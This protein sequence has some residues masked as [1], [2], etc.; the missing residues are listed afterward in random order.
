MPTSSHSTAC[1]ALST[2]RPY[3]CRARQSAPA[4]I[5]FDEID[6]LAAARSEGSSGGGVGARVLSQLLTEMDGLQVIP[7]LLYPWSTQGIILSKG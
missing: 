2:A 7:Q 4:I 1:T 3:Y 5:F 6:G